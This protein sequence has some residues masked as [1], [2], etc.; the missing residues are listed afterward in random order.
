MHGN[1]QEPYSD[2]QSY[3]RE[4]SQYFVANKEPG[5]FS[6]QEY[7]TP[8]GYGQ[9]SSYNPSQSR[10]SNSGFPSEKRE[11]EFSANNQNW[12]DQTIGQNW[13]DPGPDP[14]WQLNRVDP[15]ISVNEGQRLS[16]EP[17]GTVMHSGSNRL[18]NPIAPAMQSERP[19]SQ[20]DFSKK[21][22]VTRIGDVRKPGPPQGHF[23][24]RMTPSMGSTKQENQGNFPVAGERQERGKSPRGNRDRES[25]DARHGRRDGSPSRRGGRDESY[26]RGG[27]SNHRRGDSRHSPRDD[28]RRESSRRGREDSSSRRG[29]SHRRGGGDRGSK[30]TDSGRERTRSRGS[31]RDE[32]DRDRSRDKS[33]GRFRDERGRSNDRSRSDRSRDDRRRDETSRDTSRV[34]SGSS[35]R[36]KKTNSDRSNPPTKESERRPL[37]ST[38]KATGLL[39]LPGSLPVPTDKSGPPRPTPPITGSKFNLLKTENIFQIFLL[40]TKFTLLYVTVLNLFYI[41]NV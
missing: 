6:K 9:D 19:Y 27:D 22:L 14:S 41:V 1:Y 28:S 15:G 33:D 31:R 4:A 35:D 23:P 18:Q 21:N 40:F 26:R 20:E 37:P 24:D 5:V 12:N 13:Q 38:Q 32:R 30:D 34:E 8:Q 2:Q 39:P 36:S 25:E 10:Y 17:Q 7:N 3:G 29:E 16:R 11:D